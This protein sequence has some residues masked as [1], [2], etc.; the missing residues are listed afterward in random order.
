VADEIFPVKE[1]TV[2]LYKSLRQ[3]VADTTSAIRLLERYVVV[4]CAF[5]WGA[6]FTVGHG[7]SWVSYLRW[8]PLVLSVLAIVR[9]IALWRTSVLIGDYL[10][11]VEAVCGNPKA[12]NWEHT[13]QHGHRFPLFISNVV[14]WTS[15]PALNLFI[16]VHVIPC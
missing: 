16:A 4:G 3:E 14:F 9:A 6:V 10:K 2:E 15:I 7:Q 12:F 13:F 5:I 11:R 1:L 8:F